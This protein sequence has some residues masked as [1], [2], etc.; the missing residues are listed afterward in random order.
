MTMLF[1][2]IVFCHSGVE[3][4]SVGVYFQLWFPVNSCGS[5]AEPSGITAYDLVLAE[6]RSVSLLCSHPSVSL[7]MYIQAFLPSSKFSRGTL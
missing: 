7:Y 2:I 3:T 5:F 6:R 1:L 4:A